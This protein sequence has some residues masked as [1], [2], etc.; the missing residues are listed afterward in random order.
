MREEPPWRVQNNVVTSI[1]GIAPVIPNQ[2]T[3]RFDVLAHKSEREQTCL[4]QC[5]LPAVGLVA[6]VP[7][8][9]PDGPNQNPHFQMR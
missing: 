6:L 1:D 2:G 3:I 9:L 7:L 4:K 8:W 5:S